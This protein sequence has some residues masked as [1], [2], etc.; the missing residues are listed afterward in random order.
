MS[1]LYSSTLAPGR[2]ARVLSS[3]A[4]AL[5]VA[6]V[7]AMLFYLLDAFG[8]RS[9]GRLT[10]AH[11][12]MLD[13]DQEAG[14]GTW[15]S[16][17]MLLAVGQ[18]LLVQTAVSRR[19]ADGLWRWWGVLAVGFHVLSIDEVAGMHEYLNTFLK[20]GED[21]AVWTEFAWIFVVVSGAAYLPF[22]GRLPRRTA[23]L[24]VVAG[25]V[26]TGGAVGIEH[27]SPDDVNS[28]SYNLWTAVEEALEM[29]GVI[30]MTYAVI[31]HVRDS[32]RSQ[33]RVDVVRTA[34]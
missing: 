18:L 12:A 21:P 24:F 2:T 30:V 7:A 19:A 29:A 15:F 26:Y 22:L 20:R 31:D 1:T 4:V 11:V 23:R 17:L 14:F 3:A 10:Y 32:D 16:A 27:V 34:A 8:L 13:L 6:H 28:L 9:S 25:L 33:L 5:V